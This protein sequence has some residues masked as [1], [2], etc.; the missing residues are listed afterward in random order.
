MLFV[1]TE[2]ILL[3]CKKRRGHSLNGSLVSPSCNC[4]AWKLLFLHYSYK[5]KSKVFFIEACSGYQIV[6]QAE[7][8]LTT[9]LLA[10]K[11]NFPHH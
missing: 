3:N 2:G 7:V 1:R 11:Y 6:F 5:K 4:I 9:T 10:L 8:K